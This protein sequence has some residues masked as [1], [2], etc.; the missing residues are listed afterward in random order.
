MKSLICAFCAFVAT[1]CL[2][3]SITVASLVPVTDSCKQVTGFTFP[4]SPDDDEV[5]YAIREVGNYDLAQATRNACVTAAQAVDNAM[6]MFF[7][8]EPYGQTYTI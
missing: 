1:A 4:P 3:A 2:A 7:S 5:K 8:I 6:R